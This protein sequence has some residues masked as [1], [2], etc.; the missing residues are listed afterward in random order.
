M[1]KKTIKRIIIIG[2][3]VIIIGGGALLVNSIISKDK[4]PKSPDDVNLGDRTQNLE[5]IKVGDTVSAIAVGTNIRS[6]A[7]VNEEVPKWYAIDTIENDRIRAVIDLLNMAEN[8]KMLGHII[9]RIVR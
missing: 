9:D 8:N 6:S 4:K 2:A 5:N 3:S 1:E 7:K